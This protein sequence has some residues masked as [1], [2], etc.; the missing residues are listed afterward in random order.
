MFALTMLARPFD[1]LLDTRG[2][3]IWELA[4]EDVP[5]LPGWVPYVHPLHRDV[6]AV[7]VTVI[8]G[9]RSVLAT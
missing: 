6:G 8:F 3:S 2:A 4:G 9:V 1:R 5:W 7:G